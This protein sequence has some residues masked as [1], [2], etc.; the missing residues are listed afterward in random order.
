MRATSLST[1]GFVALAL[2][3]SPVAG[4]GAAPSPDASVA[5][6]AQLPPARPD[7]PTRPFDVIVSSGDFNGGLNDILRFNGDTGEQLDPFVIPGSV[8]D[9]P[10]MTGISQL[11]DPRDVVL[12]GSPF[13]RSTQV[14][15]NT[16]FVPPMDGNDQTLAFD[17]E[18]NF[19][20]TFASLGDSG[21][22]VDPGGAV[23]GPGGDFFVGSRTEGTV[24][25][26]DGETG[27]FV[28]T[29]FVDGGGYFDP[30]DIDF[31]RGFVFDAEDNLYIG[32]GAN[33]V[34]GEGQNSI[35]LVDPVTRELTVFS[36]PE[37]FSPLDV[38]LSPDGTK[39]VVSSESPFTGGSLAA[40]G[41]GSIFVF[42]LETGEV[43]QTLSPANDDGSPVIL[44][45]RGLG[46]APDGTLFASSTGN[47]SIFKFDIENG[48]F[49]GSFAQIFT[50]DADGNVTGNI[51]G[52]ALNFIG[53]FSECGQM[54]ATVT[55][56]RGIDGDGFSDGTDGLTADLLN[57][58]F[59]EGTLD[60]DGDDNTVNI[61]PDATIS[62]LD[63]RAIDLGE[64]A[65][66]NN[67]GF[68]ESENDDGIRF[69]SGSTLTNDGTIV[70]NGDE[71][72]EAS[73]ADDVTVINNG[74]I[75]A[76]E[77]GDKGIEANINL[78]V[79]NTGTITS[80]T[81]EA[82]EADGAGLTLTNSGD[83]ISPLDDAVD[84]DDDVTIINTGLIQGGENDAIE[85][86]SGTIENS[87]T[88]LS[89]SSDPEGAIDPVTMMPELDAAIDFDAGTDGN[90]DG[91]I[92]NLAGGLIEGDIGIVASPGNLDSPDTNDGAQ[93]VFN[94]GTITGRIGDA[95]LLGNGDDLF[96]QQDGGLVNGAVD[97]GEGDDIFSLL[98]TASSL[99]DGVSGGAGS[100]TAQLS[101]MF[102]ADI[103]SDFEAIEIGDTRFVGERNVTGAA[104]VIGN[105][106]FDLGADSLAVDGD[107]TL[108]EGSVVTVLTSD[109]SLDLIQ[110]GPI[111]VLSETGTFADGGTTINV[112]DDDFLLDYI[113]ELGSVT[114][115]PIAATLTSETNNASFTAFGNALTRAAGAGA[116]NPTLAS[117]INAVGNS[118]N[119][120]EVAPS[121]LPSL[122]GGVAR[123]IYE[124]Q[125]ITDD[126][127]AFRTSAPEGPG[128]W[129]QFFVRGS[130]RDATS[131]SD[132]AYDGEAIGFTVGGDLAIS[133][134]LLV[135][136]AFS[137]ASIEVEEDLAPFDETE[138]D[139]FSFTGYLGYK[140]DKIFANA[141]IGYSFSDADSVRATSF[142]DAV[143]EFD[144]DGIRAQAVA[145]YDFGGDRVEFAPFVGLRYA[146]L[147]TDTYT[148]AGLLN[149]EVDAEDID[150]FEGRVGV[151]LATRK[152]TGFGFHGRATYVYDFDN[153]P[154]V[155]DITFA[156]APSF[157]VF[158]GARPESRG[159]FTGGINFATEGGISFV[160][161]YQGEFADEYD[162]HTG[163]LSARYAF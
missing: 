68:I 163:M 60:L 74:L 2:A 141:S 32:N 12:T 87:G 154:D 65:T 157:S 62:V 153:G 101:G 61:A 70:S 110:A 102:D 77:K 161:E 83:I 51:N 152:E 44:A 118:G 80:L 26:Y 103:L 8:P 88:I 42:D 78:T 57:G 100:D 130:N 73:D 98:G 86:N 71:A 52:Q 160:L 84:G 159:E 56:E 140:A 54:D 46:F 115:T 92:T 66:V 14:L 17:I 91:I 67:A 138:I 64:N 144:L 117:Q 105:A 20:G 5:E 136:L 133:E 76:G 40:A 82:I 27:A 31:P 139:S 90:E 39:L 149:L 22:F 122:N 50:S 127:I 135:G 36:A 111:T 114:V 108:A 38:I 11:N 145:G 19:I 16:G 23:F 106:T 142:G 63:D 30:A 75:F 121:L 155:A 49:L 143:G 9:I 72:V 59:L 6:S 131:L 95:V 120:D 4:Q 15:I 33:P 129:G 7:T 58:A 48:E 137:Y 85:L 45:P 128:I 79:T 125:N 41:P 94:A 156:G 99:S 116:I 89:V 123:E 113:V 29:T 24:F 53:V 21:S 158:T 134:T 112:V 146:K 151:Q 81:S 43:L 107:L 104:T 28:P 35:L 124:T 1:T 69:G 162:S 55:C 96:E 148:E 119:I 109:D 150:F 147:S 3:S 126:L 10:G 37:D 13:D 34:T 47:G 93:Q 25:Q 18:G 132:T 97:L